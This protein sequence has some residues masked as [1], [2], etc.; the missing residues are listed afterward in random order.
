MG[1]VV[2]VATVAVSTSLVDDDSPPARAAPC[3][4]STDNTS[5]ATSNPS[6]AAT[7]RH[8]VKPLLPPAAQPQAW[9]PRAATHSI[10]LDTR[11]HLR[12]CVC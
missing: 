11:E 10:T 3:E 4:T 12:L 8:I 9:N 1:V 6:A 7:R 5:P 2:L